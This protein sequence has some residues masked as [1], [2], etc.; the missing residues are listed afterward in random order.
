ML[1]I[2]ND[3]A[4]ISNEDIEVDCWS[5]QFTDICQSCKTM[6]MSNNEKDVFIKNYYQMEAVVNEIK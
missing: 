3:C 6:G 5:C 2:Y 1:K 4:R